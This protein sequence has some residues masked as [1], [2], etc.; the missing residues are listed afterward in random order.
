MMMMTIIKAEEEEEE[1]DKDGEKGES[2]GCMSYVIRFQ[3]CRS[4]WS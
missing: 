4:L 1:E 2:K 3:L